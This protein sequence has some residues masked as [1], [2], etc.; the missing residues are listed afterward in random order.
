[1]GGN[2]DAFISIVAADPV[3]SSNHFYRQFIDPYVFTM[4]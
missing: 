2:N 1:M 4:A 3:I